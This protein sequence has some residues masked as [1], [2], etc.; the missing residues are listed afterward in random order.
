MNQSRIKP[1]VK[2]NHP[3]RFALIGLGVLAVIIGILGIVR[4][5]SF[6][7]R[8]QT[9]T[10]G[11]PTP[12]PVVE[13]TEYTFL[14]L[15]YGGGRHEGTY[16]T[17]SIMVL[18]FD[19]KTNKALLISL[20]RDLWVQV[21]MKSEESFSTKINAV[22]QMSLFPNQYP[23]IDPT[24]QDEENPSKLL[25]YVVK[26]VTGLTV[27]AYVSIDFEGFTQAINTLGGITVN[28]E[29]SF[30]DYE[31]P[32]EEKMNDLCERDEEFVQIEPIINK[33]MTEEDQEKLFA[34][35]PELK[36]F[37]T[38]IKEQPVK[39]FPCRYEELR[40]E[41]GLVEMDGETALKFARSR[42]AL[43]DGGDFNRAKR[44]QQ[45][46]DSAKDKVLSIG[47][48]PKIIPLLNDLED[49]IAT[50]LPL[51]DIQKLLKESLEAGSYTTQ[52]FVLSDTYVA[53]GYSPAGGYILVPK[54]TAGSWK[55]IR[56]AIQFT[57]LGIT[58]TPTPKPNPSLTPKIT[59]KV[60]TP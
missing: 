18:N 51:S 52:S 20:P 57:R 42:H 43:G 8:I 30:V 19:T 31:Y 35:K 34:E 56:E 32:I 28:V 54:N 46:I 60:K 33:T 55:D 45:V 5:G 11:T 50:D 9:T 13:K 38:D 58:P 59:Q 15:G 16:L 2:T 29:R 27:D 6:F 36:E 7:N 24:Y 26:D 17:D 23:N 12:T 40:F 53:D 44:Q 22:Y 21:P 14:L 48:I 25:A 10:K 39:A 3:L 1:I 4:I 41:K 37:V 47:F 49:H